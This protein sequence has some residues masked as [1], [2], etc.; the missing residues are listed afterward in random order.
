MIANAFI[1]NYKYG[2]RG[3]WLI[4]DEFN[5]APIDLALGDALTALGSGNGGVL[6]VPTDD[7]IKD[8]PIPKDFRII[9]TLNS[10]DRNYLNQISEALKRRFSFIEILPPSRA[11]RDEEQDIVLTYKSSHRRL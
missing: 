2:F 11:K 1:G 6:R 3:L 10:F 8:L 4:I 5:R 9:G 7:G